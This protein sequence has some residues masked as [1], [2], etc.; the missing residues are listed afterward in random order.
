MINNELAESYLPTQ[1]LPAKKRKAETA[2]WKFNCEKY[3]QELHKNCGASL[4][5]AAA[6]QVFHHQSPRKDHQRGSFR[7]RV[8]H[9][10]GDVIGLFCRG[11]HHGF[12]APHG[13]RVAFGGEGS[14][15]YVGE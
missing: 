15:N 11:V 5:T 8:V 12:F 13:T 4:S 6:L 3:L 1:G 2:E 7:D 9:P 10:F 14:P